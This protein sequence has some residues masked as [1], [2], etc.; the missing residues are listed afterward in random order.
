MLPM[1]SRYDAVVRTAAATHLP[2]ASAFCKTQH[3]R[4]LVPSYASSL[5]IQLAVFRYPEK[6]TDVLISMN[7]PI[8]IN[9]ESA[10][11]QHTGSGHKTAHTSAPRLFA[12]MLNAFHIFDYSLFG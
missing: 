3:L 5:Q 8:Y 7:T 12:S 10:A 11:A 1:I 6:G 9:Q 4:A 2:F